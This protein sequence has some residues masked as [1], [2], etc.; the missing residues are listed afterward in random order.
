MVQCLQPYPVRYA[1]RHSIWNLR[2]GNASGR[3][4]YR[5]GFSQIEFLSVQ[6]SPPRMVK[7]RLSNGWVNEMKLDPSVVHS[8]SSPRAQSTELLRFS[9][10]EVGWEWMSFIVRRL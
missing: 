4:P 1:E 5:A 6:A 7:W 2:P 3:S 9:R 8:L 10:E